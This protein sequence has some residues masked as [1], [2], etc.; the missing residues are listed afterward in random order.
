MR[1]GHLACLGASRAGC[2]R[3]GARHDLGGRGDKP[4][5]RYQGVFRLTQAKTG[6]ATMSLADGSF[7]SCGKAA[8]AGFAAKVKVIRH[9]WG[10]GKGQFRTKGK[11][12]A[13]TIRG[14]TWDTIDRCDGTLVKVTK[15]RVAVTDFKR[16][17][18]VIVKA[19][20]SHLA[21]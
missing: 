1:F 2:R 7:K 15:G 10:N 5:H 18:T 11:Y 6:L 4:A 21:K 8:S 17:K 9:L 19:G 16:H 13:A 12:A 3:R 20:H 14:T